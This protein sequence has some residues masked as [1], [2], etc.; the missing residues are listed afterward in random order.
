MTRQPYPSDVSDAERAFV[1]STGSGRR[2]ARRSLPR[3]PCNRPPLPPRR[4]GERGGGAARAGYDGHQRPS[5][6]L[7]P[8][9]GK[10]GS[11]VHV[12]VDTLGQLL[13]AKR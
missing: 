11:K 6:S 1:A 10:G 2:R 8:Q 4:G 7:P 5:L 12:A 9:G 13:A 3:A